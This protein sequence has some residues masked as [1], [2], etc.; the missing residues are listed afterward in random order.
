MEPAQIFQVGII[1]VEIALG[2]RILAKSPTVAS[3]PAFMNHIAAIEE[4]MG[5][6]YKQ[7][8]EFCLMQEGKE[9]WDPNA[10]YV[11][12]SLVSKGAPEPV[13]MVSLFYSEVF[14]R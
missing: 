11:A 5:V 6:P 1:L 14:M 8:C 9:A 3:N 7:A 2:R 4:T 12:N 13:E 10:K